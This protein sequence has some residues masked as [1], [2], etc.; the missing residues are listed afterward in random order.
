ALR[1]LCKCTAE[2][3]WCTQPQTRRKPAMP[4]T[5]ATLPTPSPAVTGPANRPRLLD[6]LRET[7]TRQGY[8]AATIGSFVCWVM[9]FIRFH[10]LR[11][12]QELQLPDVGRFLDEVVREGHEPLIAI[13]A[14]RTALAFLYHD[15]LQL[16]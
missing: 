3:G 9:R 13:G 10:G 16:D 8:A 1:N 12:P 2:K 5:V 14:A 11:H 15:V 6:V 4:P 7:A